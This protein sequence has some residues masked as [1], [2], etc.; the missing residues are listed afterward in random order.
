M[1]K[2]YPSFNTGIYINDT[3][4]VL[5]IFLHHV[6]SDYPRISSYEPHGHYLV[7]DEFQV[8]GMQTHGNA[9][10]GL[11]YTF[12]LCRSC[13]SAS[14]NIDFLIVAEDHSACSYLAAVAVIRGKCYLRG[15]LMPWRQHQYLTWWF[16]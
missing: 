8:G 6:L 11:L 1:A 10:A 2:L 5:S 14:M 3:Q 16:N 4:C 13:R 9:N 7:G 12:Y 15:W